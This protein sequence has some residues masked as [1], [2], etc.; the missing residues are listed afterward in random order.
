VLFA[1]YAA[2]I[3]QW[4]AAA[5]PARVLELAAGTGI[6]TRQL[7]NRSPTGAG[8]TATD[9]NLPMLAVARTKFQPEEQVDFC[10]ADATALPFPDNAFDAV[11]GQF[12]VMFFPDKDKSFREV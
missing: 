6:A 12:G 1:D 9:L 4:T 11:V 8:I 10:P 3:A 2:D 7:R 5:G